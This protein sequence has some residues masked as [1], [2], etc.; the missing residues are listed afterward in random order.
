MSTIERL[1]VLRDAVW[2]LAGVLYVC[3]VLMMLF[4][5]VPLLGAMGR[6]GGIYSLI[7]VFTSILLMV[8]ILGGLWVI[9][10]VQ[11]GRIRSNPLLLILVGILLLALSMLA[12]AYGISGQEIWNFIKIG[13]DII[14]NSFR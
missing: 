6:A 10:L 14:L 7:S 8:A 12:I 1:R 2:S 9:V 11:H 3:A 5:F 4:I 13:F